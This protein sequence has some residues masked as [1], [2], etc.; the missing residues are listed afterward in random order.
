MARTFL[1]ACSDASQGEMVKAIREEKLDG[2]VIASCSPKLHLNTFRAM[3]L[4]AGLN[5]YMYSQVNI[6]EQCSWAHRHDREGATEK[7]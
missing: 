7:A 4:R 5:P 2:V 3:A 1:F 6:R